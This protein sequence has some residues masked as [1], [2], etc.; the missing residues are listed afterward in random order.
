M[1][2]DRCG[3]RWGHK[4]G[5]T[6]PQIDDDEND[7]MQKYHDESD[8]NRTDDYDMEHNPI[9]KQQ[10]AHDEQMKALLDADASPA[11]MMGALPDS[12]GPSVMV[13]DESPETPSAYVDHDDV[14]VGSKPTQALL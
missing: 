8:E 4:P 13:L 6:W 12:V 14:P 2:C 5:C 10:T 11:P 1:V 3:V 9:V 7:D